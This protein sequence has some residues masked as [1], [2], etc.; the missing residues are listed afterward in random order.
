MKKTKIKINIRERILDSIL[1]KIDS[2][3]LDEVI[4]DAI[5]KYLDLSI[6]E[7][8][9]P[10]N[11]DIL[12]YVGFQEVDHPYYVYAILDP[13]SIFNRQ[14]LGVHL[15]YTPFYVGK[16]VDDR[17]F[18]PKNHHVQG[19]IEE[20][21]QL[22]KYPIYIKIAEGLKNYEAYKYEASFICHAKMQ[23]VQLLNIAAGVEFDENYLVIEEIKKKM[24]SPNRLDDAKLKNCLLALN[25][26][27]SQEKAAKKLG[28]STRTLYRMIDR[29]NIK[30]NSNFYY[31]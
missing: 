6:M 17:I 18:S 9:D 22:G 5:I 1:S 26:E 15:E 10:M 24:N 20:I 31:I 16:G 11:I 21:N 14:I 23:D 27:R 25:Q 19:K 2:E 12:E 28:I 13:L 7:I 8:G 29:Y 3:E 30:R 4:E